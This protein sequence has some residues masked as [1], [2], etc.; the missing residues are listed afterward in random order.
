MI[1][2]SLEYT[3]FVNLF[4]GS[5]SNT[6]YLTFNLRSWETSSEKQGIG[7]IYRNVVS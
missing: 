5:L 2:L 6:E 3:Y 7:V 4:Q 1:K